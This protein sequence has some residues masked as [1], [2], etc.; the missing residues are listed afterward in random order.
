MEKMDNNGLELMLKGNEMYQYTE[1]QKPDK[2]K[3]KSIYWRV[4]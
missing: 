2:M 4:V 1:N 3:W